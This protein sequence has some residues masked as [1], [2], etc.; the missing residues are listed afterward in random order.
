MAT[1]NYASYTRN[2]TEPLKRIAHGRR[3]EQLLRII[4]APFPG[5]KVLD[6][7]CGDGHL[8]SHL[9]GSVPAEKL[10]GYDPSP[11][12][13]AQA[14]AAVVAGS[15]LTANIDGLKAKH[16]HSFNLIYC[17]EV[18][19]HLTDK[20]LEELFENLAELAAPHARIIFG[21]PIETGPSGFLKSMY[22]TVRG[23]R[24]AATFTK[25]VR[26]LFGLPISRKV[27]DVEWYGHH[28]GFSHSRLR[29]KLVSHGFVVKR[30]SC[31][32]FTLFGLALNNEI[33]FTCSRRRPS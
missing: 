7:G 25:A 21:V 9:L 30:S 27:T 23:D 11:D 15:S 32:P 17:V 13:L 31:L 4:A 5:D 33:Y 2:T 6:Y 8:F 1:L 29:K 24:Q 14:D 28:T 19:E 12:L 3:Y 18:C 16:R 20:A 26:A 22:R 10:V